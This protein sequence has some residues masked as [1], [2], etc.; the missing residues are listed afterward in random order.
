MEPPKTKQ[1]QRQIMRTIKKPYTDWNFFSFE[2]IVEIEQEPFC[3]MVP[4]LHWFMNNTIQT[5]AEVITYTAPVGWEVT[6][7]RGE[8]TDGNF[9]KA[10]VTRTATRNDK[11]LV[12][13]LL[14]HPK[15]TKAR[16]WVKVRIEGIVSQITFQEVQVPE[17][18][19]VLV[20]LDEDGEHEILPEFL[21]EIDN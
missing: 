11:G 2:K 6:R 17:F 5:K 12:E 20:T 13:V 15:I 10:L 21:E 8:V 16:I 4:F 18:K 14:T 9:E 7:I 19:T 3:V 1:V